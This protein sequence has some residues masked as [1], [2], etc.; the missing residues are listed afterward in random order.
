MD[1]KSNPTAGEFT[2][3]AL[4]WDLE[5]L[6]LDFAQAKK[7][8]AP[9]KKK[10]LT[11]VEKERL[12][13][14]LCGYSPAEIARKLHLNPGGLQVAITDLY[15]Y[16][17]ALT[18]R[19]PHT[20]KNWRDIVEWLEVAGYQKKPYQGL[21][22][23]SPPRKQ[24]WESMP[25]ISNFYG[26]TEE[27]D[28]LKQWI[29]QE[30]CRLITILGMGG[31]GK[32]ALSVKLAQELSGEFEYVIW[33][34]LRYAPP[35]AKILARLLSFLKGKEEEIFTS[36]LTGENK[37]HDIYS[38]TQSPITT[39]SE[40][41]SQLIE[42]LKRHRCLIV[43]DELEALLQP[44]ELAGRYSP[45]HQAYQEFIKR[46]GEENHK[47]CLCLTSQEKTSEV[48]ALTGPSL[49]V[50]CFSLTGLDK[51]SAQTI[52]KDKGLSEQKNHA[53]LIDLYRGNPLALKIVAA[54]IQDVFG[55]SIDEFLSGSS[56]FVGDFG[57]ILSQQFQRLSAIERQILYA[58]ALE[59]HPV[60][61]FQLRDFLR[62]RAS[63]SKLTQ[64]WES[65]RRR[66]LLENTT[67]G[68]TLQPVVMKY[69][70]EELI[71]QICNEA[72]VASRTQKV[73]NTSLLHQRL[74]LQFQSGSQADDKVLN[75]R[76]ILLKVEN[77]LRGFLQ[78]TEP[79]NSEGQ[80]SELLGLIPKP[81]II[82]H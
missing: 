63:T 73:D 80:L 16:T 25:D 15:R 45:Q 50:R 52:L 66:S 32:T 79:E 9:H 70:T 4:N 19:S 53:Q 75:Y 78:Y 67:E 62:D 29:L 76:T 47:S 41:I 6:Y 35:F 64:A 17:E 39:V 28:T 30:R 7:I 23:P 21:S 14:L 68:L 8:V 2:Q 71:K 20:I 24:D 5:R 12:R 82:G 65:L 3:A 46:I 49:P 40:E 77:E 54:T 1:A 34:S 69:V 37:F 74:L 58:L 13:G 81:S 10:G 18:Q 57:E 48:A 31:I 22:T 44:G 26:R 36:N 27:I 51:I 33:Q 42:E 55:G 60:T 56:M 61:F 11:Q 38:A 72:L 43:L 59:R